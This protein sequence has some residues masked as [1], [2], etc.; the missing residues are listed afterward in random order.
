M[1]DHMAAQAASAVR[2]LLGAADAIE[3]QRSHLTH[4]LQ[5]AQANLGA[6]FSAAEVRV[7]RH[8]TPPAQL[9]NGEK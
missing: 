9:G 7:R 4:K 1:H 5:R 6:Q 8:T 2:Q 3:S